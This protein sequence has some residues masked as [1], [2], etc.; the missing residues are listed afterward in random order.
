M[1]GLSEIFDALKC[2]SLQGMRLALKDR[3][4]ARQYC[5][6]V[7]QRYDELM[8]HGLGTMNPL[9]FIYEQGW[10]PRLIDDRVEVPIN[11]HT[12][13]GVRLDE[14]VILAMVARALR[15]SKVFEIGTFMGRTTSVLLLNTPS[16]TDIVTLDLPPDA[17]LEAVMS[18]GCI[19]TDVMLVK[20]RNVGVLL[21]ELH[22]DH[23]CQQI[24]CDSLD[25]DPAAHRHS[26][27]LGFIDGAHSRRHVEN[28]TRKMA[29]MMADRGLVF[30]HDYG[31]KGRFR[32]L[33]VYLDALAKRIAIHRVPHT[34]LAWTSADEL[35]KLT[36]VEEAQPEP[37]S[38]HHL[39]PEPRL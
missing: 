22:L 25:F 13:G 10:S 7:L 20:R 30:W 31:G 35:R 28:D 34:T 12:G 3:Q 21:R 37:A 24:F 9:N 26:V 36:W 16:T 14:L 1:A 5:S 8:E 15:P 23:R 2:A 4:L 33:T 32:A 17:D 11:I 29:I 27:E 18:S 6:Y 39:A 19:D 38:S